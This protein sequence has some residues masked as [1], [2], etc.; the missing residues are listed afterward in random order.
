VPRAV[1]ADRL[2]ALGQRG[3]RRGGADPARQPLD[4]GLSGFLLK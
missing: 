4:Q 1:Q 3:T 2:T